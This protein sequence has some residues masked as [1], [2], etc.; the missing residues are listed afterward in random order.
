LKVLYSFIKQFGR[1]RKPP[2]TEVHNPCDSG[3][4]IEDVERLLL[5]DPKTA[6]AGGNLVR[7][8]RS[9]FL[10]CLG[11]AQCPPQVGNLT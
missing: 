11:R 5:T 6:F 2:V 4:K 9:I 10:P 7:R 8:A 1:K 3:C